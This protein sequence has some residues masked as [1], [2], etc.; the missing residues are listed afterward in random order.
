MVTYYSTKDK[1]RKN[2]LRKPVGKLTAMVSV[3]TL[4]KLKLKGVTKPRIVK[5]K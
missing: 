1:K 3:S 5:V 4:K 2:A